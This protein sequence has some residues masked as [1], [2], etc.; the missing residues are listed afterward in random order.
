MIQCLLPVSYCY[1]TDPCHCITRG[2][3]GV[4][5][6]TVHAEH[7]NSLFLPSDREVS[8]CVEPILSTL[9][10]AYLW[11]SLFQFSGHLDWIKNLR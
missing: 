11:L 4:C 5:D 8:H 6:H 7:M 1:I 10:E 9:P 2:V 3:C